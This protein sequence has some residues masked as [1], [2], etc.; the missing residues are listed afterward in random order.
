[1]MKL[2]KLGVWGLFNELTAA[3]YA[4]LAQRVERWGYGALWLPEALGRDLL[5][6]SSW[7][8]A[9]TTKLQVATGIAVTYARDS[10]AALNAQYG[11]AEQSGGRFLLGLGVSHGPFVEA[12]RGHKYE[13]PVPAMRAYLDGMKQAQY[14]GAPPPERPAT[15]IAAL[16]PKMLELAASDADGAHTYNVSPDHTARAREILG[17]GKLLCAEQ[18]VVLETDPAKAR[19][20]GRRVLGYSLDLPNYRAHFLRQGFA[21]TDLENGGSDR[22]VDSIIA[23]GDEAAIRARIEMHWTAGADH[24]CIQAL[25]REG[26][27]FTPDCEAVLEL[28]APAP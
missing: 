17:P 26:M 11:L 3:E 6:A 4:A 23:W 22:L 12:V 5:V 9:N 8:L 1:M 24:V 14:H 21:E 27:A 10:L 13:K 20:I 19:A 7:L 15:V 2:G 28:L 18:K 16:G 25:P